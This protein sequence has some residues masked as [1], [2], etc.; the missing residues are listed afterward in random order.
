M[1]PQFLLILSAFLHAAW[2]TSTKVVKDKDM[3]VFLTIAVS[4]IFVFVFLML[5]DGQY[6]IGGAEGFK[7][8]FISGLFE[9]LYLISL[10]KA[11]TRTSLARA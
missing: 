3:Y 8:A 5:K 4:A 2:N 7:F 10:V 1:A 11:F 9:G 6:Q